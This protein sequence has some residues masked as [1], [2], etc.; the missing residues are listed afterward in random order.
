MADS[1]NDRL[2]IVCCINLILSMRNILRCDRRTIPGLQVTSLSFKAVASSSSNLLMRMDQLNGRIQSLTLQ[3][4]SQLCAR[5]ITLNLV[6]SLHPLC[7]W[8]SRL[9]RVLPGIT[10]GKMHFFLRAVNLS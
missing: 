5:C 2:R 7:Y 6:C 10:E 8:A 9:T 4:S 1:E 3:Q